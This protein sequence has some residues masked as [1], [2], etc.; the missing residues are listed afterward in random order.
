MKDKHWHW[1]R[2][3]DQVGLVCFI[4]EGVIVRVMVFNATLN[5]VGGIGLFYNGGGHC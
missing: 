5:S 3:A 4:M 2:M 1:L